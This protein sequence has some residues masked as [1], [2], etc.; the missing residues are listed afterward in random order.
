MFSVELTGAAE[1]TR[2]LEALP[3]AIQSALAAKAASLAE[4]L[5]DHVVQDKLSGQV[6]KARTGALRGAIKAEVLAD[7]DP[8]VVRIF[9]SSDIKYAAI[10]EF[11]GHTAPHEIRPDKAKAL[12]FLSGGRLVFARV[13]HHPG[14][15]IPE[16]SYLRS[17]L[18]D[19]AGQIITEMK[20]ALVAA[21]KT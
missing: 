6:L 3:A 11:G 21:L 1:L 4:Q 14:S 8:I 7:S 13:V 19:M 17:S 9:L 5:K 16:R 10:Q 2:R 15:A 20:A 12:A 18:A